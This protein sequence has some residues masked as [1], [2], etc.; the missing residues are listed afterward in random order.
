MNRHAPT[1]ALL[2]L[3]VLNTAWAAEYTTVDVQKVP[4]N[5]D[6]TV[7]VVK[8]VIPDSVPEITAT[9]SSPEPVWEASEPRSPSPATTSPFA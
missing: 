3:A 2:L 1:H 4:V 5:G 9:C 7:A 6:P 8:A